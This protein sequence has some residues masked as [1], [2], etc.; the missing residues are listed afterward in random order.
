M[1]ERRNAR[2]VR[3]FREVADDFIRLHVAAK[4]K[5]STRDDYRAVLDNHV[6]PAIGSIRVVDLR[7][8]DVARLHRKLART[9]Y[10]ANRALAVVSAVWNWAAKRDEVTFANNPARGI[11]RY[12]EE[13]RQRFLTREEFGRL[14]AALRDAETIGLPWSLDDQKPQGKAKHRPKEPNLR[15][16]VDPYAVAA[17]RLLIMTG[18]RLREVLHARWSYVDFER[19]LMLLPDS[20]SGAKPIYL[21]AA[22]LAILRG[23]PRVEKC[24]YIFPGK[25]SKSPRTDLKKSWSAVT[26]EAKLGGLRLHDLRHTFA[27]FGA[28]ASLG[29]PIIGKLLGH[30][31]LRRRTVTRTWTPIRCTARPS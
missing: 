22:A 5:G 3:T 31:Q 13:K 28:G 29:L 1:A 17:I 18:A 10:A 2:A 19:G 12:K 11:E 7:R 8:V 30:S 15:T 27:S 20:K 16:K 14:G 4:R 21:S 24:P 25:D 9:P 26:R 23:L 6:L